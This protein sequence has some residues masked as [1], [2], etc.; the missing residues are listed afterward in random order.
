MSRASRSGSPTV[1]NT[2]PRS[3]SVAI[4][5]STSERASGP[6]SRS[7]R[8]QKTT[9]GSKSVSR[10]KLTSARSSAVSRSS[11]V[12]MRPRRPK[13]AAASAALTAP[14]ARREKNVR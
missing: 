4:H 1:T 10:A 14:P 7:G 2:V 9:S 3:H 12:R 8:S 5:P 11:R 6:S 13:C